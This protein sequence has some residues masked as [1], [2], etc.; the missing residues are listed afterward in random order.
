MHMQQP[1]S[2]VYI[3][4]VLHV[5]AFEKDFASRD[6]EAFAFVDKFIET[7]GGDYADNISWIL[8]GF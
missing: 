7:S 2:C 1:E 5:L 4:Y 8:Y 6:V 3:C